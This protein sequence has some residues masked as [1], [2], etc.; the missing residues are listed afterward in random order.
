MFFLLMISSGTLFCDLTDYCSCYLDTQFACGFV[1]SVAD[2]A[3][4]EL[5]A[6]RIE[7]SHQTVAVCAFDVMP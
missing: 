5:G 2:S 4:W 7:A 6:C 3:R 1:T